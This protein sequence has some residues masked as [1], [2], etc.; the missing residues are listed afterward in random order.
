MK[1]VMINEKI[2]E[3]ST[4]EEMENFYSIF[5]DYQIIRR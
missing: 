2:L 5:F 4:R 3:K 1:I